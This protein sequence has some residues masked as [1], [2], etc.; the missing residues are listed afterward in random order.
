M[1]PVA[2]DGAS[3]L[4]S[5]PS[6][7][8][9]RDQQL[10]PG[11]GA[12]KQSADE[13][14]L[15]G[16]LF[17]PPGRETNPTSPS[18]CSPLRP[19]GDATDGNNQNTKEPRDP[20]N[21]LVWA[22]ISTKDH[23]SDGSPS[24]ITF[25]HS[26]IHIPPF[27]KDT[28]VPTEKGAG[29]TLRVFA[30]FVGHGGGPDFAAV[31]CEQN[32]FTA[33][34][35]AMLHRRQRARELGISR[36]CSVDGSRSPKFISGALEDACVAMDAR[37]CRDPDVARMA[38]GSG[39]CGIIL[40]LSPTT[41]FCANVGTLRALLQR[42]RSPNVVGK[43]S[44]LVLSRGFSVTTG[45]VDKREEHRIRLA[46]GFVDRTRP[47]VGLRRRDRVSGRVMAHTTHTTRAF[48]H[49]ALKSSDP[50]KFAGVVSPLPEISVIPRLHGE[51]WFIVM[52]SVW[53][54]MEDIRAMRIVSYQMQGMDVGDADTHGM[55]DRACSDLLGQCVEQGLGAM[56]LCFDGQE[57]ANSEICTDVVWI[58]NANDDSL[59]REEVVEAPSVVADSF[60]VGR[61]RETV[62][63]P[64]MA[65]PRRAPVK[66]EVVAA[67]D[68]GFLMF[69]L[70]LSMVV[71][72]LGLLLV[73]W[74]V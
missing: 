4:A 42:G 28:P 58:D 71:L 3:P 56:V 13:G 1:T 41:I 32:V 72:C 12:A 20:D 14:A 29:V 9:S 33:L 62:V 67:N 18:Q 61:E 26:T 15:L 6:Q 47:C 50:R 44:V 34:E 2:P 8:T 73:R 19:D 25:N 16:A 51:D 5:S 43:G 52:G 48:G 23:D 30:A 17:L 46:R 49:A 66:E 7:L 63:P 24:T 74:P 57:A 45:P 64:T 55:V 22:A 35:Q 37:L 27:A 54:E 60:D 38:R 69:V 10:A 31:W 53:K 39:C 36:W 68:N 70:M 21:H 11:G 59:Q 65:V 40:V